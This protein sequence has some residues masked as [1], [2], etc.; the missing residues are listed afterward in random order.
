MGKTFSNL[1]TLLVDT[2]RSLG[3]EV[4]D[5]PAHWTGESFNAEL[6]T[7]LERGSS[8]GRSERDLP[9][10]VYAVILDGTPV[11]F[12]EFDTGAQRLPFYDAMRR[13]RNQAA[14]ARSWLGS[15]ALNLQMFLVGPAGSASDGFWR[16]LAAE[17]ELDDRICRK[18]VWLP[19]QSPTAADAAVFLSRTFLARPWDTIAPA[20]ASRLDQMSEIAL[21]PGW[22]EIVDDDSLD[23]DSLVAKLIT[24][25]G[26]EA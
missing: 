11:L 22:A 5:A 3:A 7:V 9:K 26:G 2:A 18:L 12:G 19:P 23:A 8:L 6:L 16:Q 20:N 14:I 1:T 10:L 4:G 25:V 13:Y 17:A 24:A 15:Q 21:P